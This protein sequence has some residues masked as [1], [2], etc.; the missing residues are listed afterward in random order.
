MQPTWDLVIDD[1]RAMQLRLDEPSPTLARLMDDANGRDIAGR[2]RYGKPLTADTDFDSAE[3]AAD[4]SLDLAVYLKN[5]LLQRPSAP[6]D[7]RLRQVYD[8]AI[9]F[10]ITVRGLIDERDAK[11]EGGETC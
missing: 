10:A 11:T 9:Q 4:E 6:N 7:L 8:Q 3:E 5:W 1:L 2:M